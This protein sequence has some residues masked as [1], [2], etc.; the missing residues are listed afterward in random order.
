MTPAY[1][2]YQIGRGAEAEEKSLHFLTHKL[3]DVRMGIQNVIEVV[4]ASVSNHDDS[5]ELSKS[6]TEL[7][8]L[9]KRHKDLGAVLDA[10]ELRLDF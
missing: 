6:M 8:S 3:K 4:E 7:R 1:M 10:A 5:L 2:S 9:V